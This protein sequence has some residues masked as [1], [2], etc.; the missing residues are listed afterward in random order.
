MCCIPACWCALRL[1]TPPSPL[2]GFLPLLLLSFPYQCNQV[3]ATGPAACTLLHHCAPNKKILGSI[4]LSEVGMGG[5]GLQPS[6]EDASCFL[7]GL[8]KAP[9]LIA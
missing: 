4:T 3:V 7:Y 6:A 1:P 8:G 9:W 2:S 5:N